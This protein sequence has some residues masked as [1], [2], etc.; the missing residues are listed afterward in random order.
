MT[1]MCGMLTLSSCST[2]EVINNTVAEPAKTVPEFIEGLSLPRST[3]GRL[4][5]KGRKKVN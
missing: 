3:E 5:P 2:E 1:A 4:L